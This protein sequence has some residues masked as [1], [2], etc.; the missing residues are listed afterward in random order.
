MS[1]QLPEGTIVRY[2]HD[3]PSGIQK[4]QL[5]TLPKGGK[6]IA[7]ILDKDGNELARGESRCRGDEA[8]NKKIGRSISLERALYALDDEEQRR[9]AEEA[10]LHS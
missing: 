7:R 4:D 6:T 3:R 9:R 1:R 2:W 10:M 8:Y 5:V